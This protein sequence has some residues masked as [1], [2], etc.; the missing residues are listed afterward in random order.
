MHTLYQ[1]YLPFVIVVAMVALQGC[2]ANRAGVTETD[3]QNISQNSG[4]GLFDSNNSTQSDRDGDGIDDADEENGWT[5]ECNQ[6]YY[7]NP[8]KWDSDGDGLRD[9]LEKKF[10]TD[11][12]NPDTDGD[13][14]S[15]GDEL[16]PYLGSSY[17]T[18]PTDNDSDDDGLWDGDEVGDIGNDDISPFQTD[19]T[20]GDSD[21]DGLG[22]GYEAAQSKT[23][24]NSADSDSDGVT[25]G[26]EVCGTSDYPSTREESGEI[27]SVNNHNDISFKD[28]HDNDFYND[29]LDLDENNFIV[30]NGQNNLY[31]TRCQT[32]AD[33]NS[34][35]IYDANDTTNDSDGDGRPNIN[36]RR[37]GTDP[38]HAGKDYNQTERTDEVNTSIDN[39]YYYPWI[40]QTD[41]GEKMIK[42]GFIYVPK[43]DSKGFWI[44]KYQA[45]NNNNNDGT[46][47]FIEGGDKFDNVSSSE[48]EDYISNSIPY[49][50]INHTIHLPTAAQYDDLSPAID[51]HSNGCITIKNKPDISDGNMPINSTKTLCE[52]VPTGVVEK[53]YELAQQKTIIIDQN[54]T[55]EKGDNTSGGGSVHF[56]AAT[57]YIE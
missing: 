23:D 42:A 11:P 28:D 22:D 33:Y 20:Q 4:Q 47:K 12:S 34:D 44:S 9:G 15:D 29:T 19:P 45:V 6:T 13:G 8:D 16:K 7:S 24:P 54:A 39:H 57:D 30:L 3:L 38:L 50:N 18:D 37:R 14:L 46:V 56:R 1:K 55:F 17:I 40:S 35:G 48:A 26:I 53:N 21:H 49:L 43:S 36:E 2:G 10:C 31:D 41:S 25:D 52:I 27:V 51:S 32:P 5:N